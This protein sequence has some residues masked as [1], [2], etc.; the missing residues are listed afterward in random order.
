M[1]CSDDTDTCHRIDFIDF[2]FEDIQKSEESDDKESSE[3]SKI[4]LKQLPDHLRYAFLGDNSAFPVIIS[5]SLNRD[6]EDK[7]LKVLRDHKA[8]L[9]WS[10]ADIEGISPTVCMH[11][12]LMED[13]YKPSIEHQR[14]LNPVMKEVVPSKVLKLLKAGIIFAISDSEWVSPVQIAIAPE[15]QEKTTFTCPY[16]TFAYRRMSFGLYNAPATF[17]RCMMAIFTNMVEDI[18]EVFMNDFLVFGTSFDNCLHNIS[19]VLQHCEEK[20]LVLNWEKC[21]F[22]VQEGIVLG[23]HVSA[24]G[25]EVD[26]AKIDTIA[27]LP[28]PTNVKGIQSFLGHVG[29]Y[30]RFIKDFSKVAKP[31]CNLLEKDTTFVFDEDCLRAF[32]T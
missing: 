2:A 7:L 32:E 6:E 9:G 28:P 27:K 14:R 18:M 12:I 21:H 23:H 25:L 30:K 8:A 19:L 22:M 15:D 10:I 5:S 16:G 26:R 31:L 3:S 24:R 13:S 29:F 20:N 4:E 11:K 17:Q 1:K